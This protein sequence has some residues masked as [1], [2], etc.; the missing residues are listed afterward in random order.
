MANSAYATA[1][2]ILASARECNQ[3]QASFRQL[4]GARAE[5]VLD[6]V[7]AT[8]TTSGVGNRGR[9]WIW[10]DL[11]DPQFSVVGQ[12]EL[13]SLLILGSPDTP[14]WLVVEDFNR[15]KRDS[16]FWVFEAT[17]EAA[18]ATLKNHHLL[19]FYIVSRALTWLA[20]ENHHNLIFAAGD[21]AVA[22]LQKIAP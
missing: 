20:G 21:H 11:R 1:N 14:V 13:E 17:L 6:A 9:L 10:D 12:L 18:V 15:T 19:E 5:A 4:P 8:F 16:P 7:L 2:S 3:A 22:A